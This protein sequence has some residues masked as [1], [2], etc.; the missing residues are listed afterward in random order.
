M[1]TTYT[2]AI[3]FNN[4]SARTRA[5]KAGATWNADRKVWILTTDRFRFYPNLAEFVVSEQAQVE[6]AT[7][8]SGAGFKM[9]NTAANIARVNRLGFDAIED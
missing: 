2:L 7:I 4:A 1:K 9:E 5:K 6:P 8:E 3:P